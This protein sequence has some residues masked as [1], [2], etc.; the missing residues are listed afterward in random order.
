MTCKHSRTPSEPPAS[1]DPRKAL[2]QATLAL[3]R[4]QQ[5]MGPIKAALRTQK[6]PASMAQ[7][8]V[9]LMQQ[10]KGDNAL[11]NLAVK[12]CYSGPFNHTA[13]Q[14]ALS[15]LVARH[16][17]FRTNFHFENNKLLQVIQPMSDF[18]LTRVDVSGRDF[19]AQHLQ[20][21]IQAQANR[22]FALQDE[23]LL[24]VTLFKE[25]ATQHHMLITVH[26]LVFDGW[27]FQIMLGELS[28]LYA[29][30]LATA[31]APL[32]LDGA[33]AALVAP[34]SLAPLRI[35]YADYALWQQAQ[36][37]AQRFSPLLDYWLSQM[38]QAPPTSCFAADRLDL[39][40]GAGFIGQRLSEPVA[41]QLSA[42]AKQ[43]S[44]TP[45]V[46][47]LSAF[48]ALFYRRTAATDIVIGGAFANRNQPDMHSMIGLLVN[49]LPLRSQLHPDMSFA[50]LLIQVDQ[51]V[52]GAHQHRELPF[53]ML[54]KALQLPRSLDASPLFQMVLNYLNY[55][56]QDWQVPGLALHTENVALARAK[57]P[58]T[59]TIAH[60]AEGLQ[61]WAE[62]DKALFLEDT[63]KQLLQQFNRLLE[64]VI[65]NPG[66]PL[67]HIPLRAALVPTPS[68]GPQ[69][70]PSAAHSQPSLQ[71]LQS[72][73]ASLGAAFE[74]QVDQTPNAIALVSGSTTLSYQTLDA[75]ANQLAHYLIAQ[76]IT[77]GMLVGVAL[78]RSPDYTITLLAVLKCAATFVPLDLTSAYTRQ[79]LE[80]AGVNALII[81]AKCSPLGTA[82]QHLTL[83][84]DALAKAQIA[85]YSSHRLQQTSTSHSPAYVMF[86][87]GSTGTPKGVCL[88]HRGIIQ[89]VKQVNYAQLDGQQSLLQLAA[90]NFDAALFEIWGALL[91]GAKLVLAPHSDWSVSDIERLVNHHQIT[92]LWLTT[93]LFEVFM[94]HRPEI[95]RQVR[96]LLVGGDVLSPVHAR[97]L[98]AQGG[99]TQLINCYGPTENTT[100]SSYFVVTSAALQRYSQVPIG[101]AV[102]HSDIQV[103]DS[104]RQPVPCGVIGEAYVGG[105]GLMLG[106]LGDPELSR[107][108]MHT[109]QHSDGRQITL[110]QTGDWVRYHSDGHLEFIARVDTQLKIRGFRVDPLATELAIKNLPSVENCVVSSQR[111]N[112]PQLIAYIVF[113]PSIDD[114]PAALAQLQTQ[115]AA[116]LPP[117][118]QPHKLLPIAQLPLTASGKIDRQ[119]L[120]NTPLTPQPSAPSAAQV[121]PPAGHIIEGN[122]IKGK[123]IEDKLLSIF[124][125]VLAQQQI[126]LHDDFFI[127]G[128]DSLLS[129]ALLVEIEQAFNLD[130]PL[131]MVFEHPTIAALAQFLRQPQAPQRT[132]PLALPTGLIEIRRGTAATPLFIVPGGRGGTAEMTMY[133][134]ATSLMTGPIPIYAFLIAQLGYSE[135]QPAPD[136]ATMA[137]ACI[138]IMQQT[139]ATGPYVIAGECIGGVVAFEIAR[140]L[141]AQQ[142]QVRLL[143]IDSWCP[144]PR[145][146]RHYHF[147]F[148]PKSLLLAYAATFSE[149]LTVLQQ[150]S[151]QHLA[152]RPIAQ[153][154]FAALRF[155]YNYPKGLARTVADIACAIA[156]VG[157]A[158]AGAAQQFAFEQHYIKAAMAYRP[159]TCPQTVH[160][161]AC[162]D[163]LG[164]GISEDWQVHCQQ[165][166]VIESVPGDHEHYF[167]LSAAQI[168]RYLME[169]L[170]RQ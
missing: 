11:Y 14:Q 91:N 56:R 38:G 107:Q 156:A 12:Q 86:T 22:P 51:V 127:L 77:A 54:L 60:T 147:Y 2:F 59:L 124:Q 155:L 79:A 159:K 3:A 121:Q 112:Q 74:A 130:L 7:Q 82:E 151:Q 67:T 111:H 131:S 110:Y 52:L 4:M 28:T 31:S 84:L 29:Q 142:Q 15:A 23:C 13:M 80:R 98:L 73:H 55:P 117:Y 5:K 125:R 75:R 97:K 42:F 93:G 141:R 116:Q 101:A 136:V 8:G 149:G 109:V 64:A 34:T 63:I 162:E 57:Y 39:P 96:Q 128:G 70:V 9:W 164:R 113:K 158:P 163:N 160:L 26:H 119:A 17:P 90:L 134:R 89:L 48:K 50:A 58:L 140:Q 20:S 100:F 168:S 19:S 148:K 24:R 138:Q 143:L 44:V 144:S 25:H 123:S 153:G 16:E 43:Q 53:E 92:T 68:A 6:L 47:L 35:Q 122:A 45:Y 30:Y 145:A 76:G 83:S 126:H 129:L 18:K 102:S 133:T 62:Y 1:Q 167:V 61:C 41:Q 72:Q 161:L 33:S 170:V 169:Y 95:F 103:L 120:R 166:L 137:T 135:G 104:A 81:T 88:G 78:Q 118:L 157:R 139:Q 27:S 146:A 10:I 66:Q 99:P 108:K 150:A 21:L 85:Q 87:S 49:T 106:Y 152:N 65:A 114:L 71:S 105:S 46:V 40:P 115:L 32:A 37:Q 69:H 154:Y 132:P 165:P 36:I 94:D